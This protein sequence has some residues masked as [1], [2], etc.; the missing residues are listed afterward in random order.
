MF[1]RM[2]DPTVEEQDAQGRIPANAFREENRPLLNLS[3]WADNIC[4]TS[5]ERDSQATKIK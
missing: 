1:V 2:N 4:I 5:S 3:D